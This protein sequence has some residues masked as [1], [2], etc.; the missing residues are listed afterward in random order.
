MSLVQAIITKDFI[1]VGADKRGI[2]PRR[3]ILNN[4]NKLIKLNNG[5]IF[6]CTGGVFDNF[7]LFDG[8]CY[9]SEELGFV[10]SE[11]TFDISYNDF[12]DVLSNRFSVLYQEHINE[13]T[14]KHY[15]IGSIVCGFN[16]SQ[17]EVTTFNLGGVSGVID[18]IDKVTK[19]HDFPYKGIS[20]GKPIHI[21]LLQELIEQGF[22]KNGNLTIRQYKNI[23]LEVFEKGSKIDKTINNVVCFEKIKIKDVIL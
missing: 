1:L 18:G 17:F 8:Y 10:N 14:P 5:I 4:C 9:Y 12:V 19:A 23:M 11:D 3:G 21:K 16:G 6:G 15:D 2:H 13:K 22:I 20:S 7:K